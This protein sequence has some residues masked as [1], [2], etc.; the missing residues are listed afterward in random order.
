MPAILKKSFSFRFIKKRFY[1]QFFAEY[2]Y[3]NIR[4]LG[5]KMFT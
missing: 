3:K 4:N 2:F 1:S 5:I